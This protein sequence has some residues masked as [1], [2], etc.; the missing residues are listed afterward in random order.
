MANNLSIIGAGAWGSALAIALSDNFDTIYLHT[1]TQKEVDTLQ[2]KHPALSVNYASNI[3]LT[4]DLSHVQDSHSVLI[5]VPSYGFTSTLKTLQPLLT[6]KQSVAW[7]TKGFDTDG[8]CFLHESFE[9]IL[10][11]HPSCVISGPSFAFE[12][13]SRKPTALSVAAKDK[14]IQSHW[15]QVLNTQALRA[16]TNDDVIGVEVGG[17]VK[18]VLAIAAGIAAG[19][20]YGASAQA[21]LITRGLAEM[22]RLGV[23]LGANTSTFNGLSGLGDLVLTCSDDLSRNRQFGK[24]LAKNQNAKQA[25]NSVGAT[26][27]GFNTLAL[28]LSQAKKHQIEMPICEQVKQV[29]DGQATPTQAVNRLMSRVQTHE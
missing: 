14:K 29:V 19:L 21:A 12:V 9:F 24:A 1:H 25:L 8:Q 4:F 11:K 5:A 2:P 28:V 13:A 23:A 10:D 26:V 3:K 6:E 16:Y 7:A 20:D 18:N 27:E 22:I 17:S 15:A